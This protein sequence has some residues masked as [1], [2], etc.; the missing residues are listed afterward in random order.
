M[1]KVREE[2]R[3]A[4]LSIIVEDM[5]KTEELNQVIHSFAEYVIGR[6]G[7]P[8]RQ[9]KL[10]IISLVVD[11]PQ[12]VISTLSGKIGRIGGVTSKTAYAKTS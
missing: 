8:Y 5:G 2:T 7:I 1:D 11:A 12:N 9:K 4:V 3:I 6:M 10:N